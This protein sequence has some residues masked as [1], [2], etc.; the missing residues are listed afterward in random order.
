ML[1]PFFYAKKNGNVIDARGRKTC[2]LGH[3]IAVLS[4]KKEDGIFAEWKWEGERLIVKNDRYGFYPLYYYHHNNE[5]YISPSIEKLLEEGANREF[6]YPAISVFL[7]LGFYIGEDTPFKYIRALPPN[8]DFQWENGKLKIS[9][10]YLSKN[11]LNISEDGA[12]DQYIYLFRQSMKRRLPSNDNFIVP[13]S[14]GRD[15]RH[16]VL[17]L[18]HLG[19]KPK[20]CVTV[21]PYS[22]LYDEDIYP[23][24]RISKALGINYIL[25]D[26]G[27][28]NFKN[29]IKNF[30][31]TNFCADEHSWSMPMAN[32]LKENQME[33]FY[34]GIG[35]DVFHSWPGEIQF[36][37]SLKS[38]HYDECSTLLSKLWQKPLEEKIKL[39]LDIEF[40]SKVNFEC[41][42]E[43]L[44]EELKKHAEHPNPIASFYVW[45]RTR[46]EIALA[47][48]AINAGIPKAYSPYLDH[49][50]FDF[51]MTLPQHI[52]KH[53]EFHDK[54]IAR[55]YP[56]YAHIPYE[57][58]DTIVHG[59]M[60]YRKK[61]TKDFA[62]YYITNFVIS[63]QLI[64]A[65][66]FFPRMLKCLINDKYCQ[67]SWWMDPPTMLYLIEL[68]KLQKMRG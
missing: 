24:E 15:S 55:S 66:H 23:A 19:Y 37:D 27:K 36:A 54:T 49:D 44:S 16:I 58:N 34:D 59:T 2:L 17:E 39:I 56:K 26:P 25:L 46:R 3:K 43:H 31:L 64:R 12:I 5:I 63:S 60:E 38:G 52:V 42:V 30:K 14:A 9:G 65:K 40:Y 62:K 53:K 22:F 67:S 32:Y 35:G 10:T 11:Q 20:A 4:N 33:A 48:Y 1:K 6:D 50:L 51:F 18:N 13:L 47:P 61:F 41:A 21:R 68:E 8:V 29:E 7:R 45:N 57:Q 28:H